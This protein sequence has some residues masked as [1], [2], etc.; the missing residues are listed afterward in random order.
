MII[1]IY[2]HKRAPAMGGVNGTGKV[3]AETPRKSGHWAV[4]RD[5]D[6]T[7]GKCIVEEIGVTPY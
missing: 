7:V 5:K 3:T 1:E 2:Y 6:E 4:P